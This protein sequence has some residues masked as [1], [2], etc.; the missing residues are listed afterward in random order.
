[1]WLL[2]SLMELE[3]SVG[4]N[5]KKKEK[6]K[7]K[8]EIKHNPVITVLFSLVM[9]NAQCINCHRQL[10]YHL[11]MSVFVCFFPSVAQRHN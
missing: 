6:K 8:K 4:T 2:F 1:M 3:S 5:K 9:E 11:W 10:R 7:K